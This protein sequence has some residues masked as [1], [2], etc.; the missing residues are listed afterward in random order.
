MEQVSF[1]TSLRIRNWVDRDFKRWELHPRTGKGGLRL[2]GQT[3]AGRS[4]APAAGAA[5]GRGQKAGQGAEL[6]TLERTKVHLCGTVVPPRPLPPS[7]P[8]RIPCRESA[9][10]RW[11]SPGEQEHSSVGEALTL[12]S[13][14]VASALLSQTAESTPCQPSWDFSPRVFF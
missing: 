1:I 2:S 9:Q 10:S 13:G 12:A 8:L 5:E 6:R 7:S 3:E 4:W 11:L 14:A